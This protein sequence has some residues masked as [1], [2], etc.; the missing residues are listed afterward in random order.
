MR[1]MLA[2][3]ALLCLAACGQS[4]DRTAGDEGSATLDT[5]TVEA[6]KAKVKT[7]INESVVNSL[8]REWDGVT[9]SQVRCILADVKVTQLEDPSAD[10]A[11]LAVFD[12]CGVDPAVTGSR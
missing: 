8:M 4:D 6:Y 3:V 11:V 12:R 10:P 7:T 2:P 5:E 1:L 9:E